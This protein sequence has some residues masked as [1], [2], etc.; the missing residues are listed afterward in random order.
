MSEIWKDVPG[1]EGIYQASSEGR[2]KSLDRYSCNGKRLT[3]KIISAN[4]T[5]GGYIVDILCKNGKHKTVRRHRI[6]AITFIKNPDNKQKVNHL[7]GIKTDNRVSNLEWA[8]HREN[9]DHA[10]KNGLIKQPPSQPLCS[11][12]QIYEG[13]VIAWYQSLKTAELIT[14]ISSADICKCCKEKRKNAGGYSWK[15]KEANYEWI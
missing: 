9:T 15:Y 6:I 12:I 3:G 13:T 5:R 1:Y 7:N 10:W 2:L 8:T 4:D 11:V 14:G